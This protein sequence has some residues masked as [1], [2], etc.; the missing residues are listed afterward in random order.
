MS[1]LKY[2][3]AISLIVLAIGIAKIIYPEITFADIAPVTP[4]YNV[5]QQTAFSFAPLILIPTLTIVL[6]LI[7]FRKFGFTGKKETL[8]I[9]IMN[10]I[11]LPIMYI[12]F[13]LLLALTTIWPIIFLV[14]EFGVIL[15]EGLVL[16]LISREKPLKRALLASL[17]ANLVSIFVGGLIYF[18]IYFFIIQP[19]IKILY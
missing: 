8:G 10:L 1:I 16:K 18:A 4:Y 11:S 7:V 3:N 17:S 14:C 5:F 19:S 2:K 15:L 13:F 12:F 6:E 9:V